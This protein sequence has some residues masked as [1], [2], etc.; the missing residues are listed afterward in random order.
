MRKCIHVG[1]VRRFQF[2]FSMIGVG[3]ATES[4]EDK[5]TDAFTTGRHSCA[6]MFMG[7]PSAR[8]VGEE[9]AV[10]KGS[11]FSRRCGSL[12]PVQR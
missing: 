9:I 3:Q 12:A 1:R 2:G 8:I 6:G 5:E 10:G 11:H 4:I 7:P